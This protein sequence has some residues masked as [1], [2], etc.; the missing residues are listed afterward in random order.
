MGR[1]RDGETGINLSPLHPFTP[2]PLHLVSLSAILALA[3]FLRFYA[4]DTSSLWSDE[5]NTWALIQRSFSQIAQDAA[6]DIHPPGY[7]WLLKV[8]SMIFGTS[9]YAMRSFSAI[10]GVLLVWVIYAIAAK[11]QFATELQTSQM[12]DNGSRITDH[13]SR[14]TQFTIR[15]A[16][17]PLL[18]ALLAALN[19]FQIYYSQE[20]RMYILLALESA[21]LMWAVVAMG[22]W[23]DGDEI[24]RRGMR[25]GRETIKFNV[26]NQLPAQRR[27]RPTSQSTKAQEHNVVRWQS[28]VVYLICAIAGLWTHYSFPIIL[29]AA[30]LYWLIHLWLR[31]PQHPSTPAPQH[32]LTFIVLNLL[33]L[34]AF[35]PW[36]PTAL[37]RVF[38]WPTAGTNLP[39]LD[40]LQLVLRTLLLGPIHFSSQPLWFGLIAAAILPL[41]GIIALRRNRAVIVLISVAGTAYRVDVCSWALPGRLPEISIS[42]LTCLVLADS[43]DGRMGGRRKGE[44]G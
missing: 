19:P 2:S 36:L 29:V 4:L 9:A 30:G 13:G 15:N 38:A 20:A 25:L 43:G 35:L 26:E 7:Y 8:W 6:A 16:H 31:R 18:A 22:R 12:V 33:V 39:V 21:G 11:M 1:E 32:P 23:G 41:L 5:G 28:L 44:K 42:Y 24:L 27:A 14:I 3:A 37:T 17:F 34:L 40:G 10:C